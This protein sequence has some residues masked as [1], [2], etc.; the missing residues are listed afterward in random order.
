[1]QWAEG[2][3]TGFPRGALEFYVEPI[4]ANSSS[5]AVDDAFRTQRC[6]ILGS[7]CLK[8]RKSEPQ[9]TIG[10]CVVG[11]QGLPLV[12]CP[13][14]LRRST[15]VFEEAMHL[16]S[17][18]QDGLELVAIPEIGSGARGSIDY[19]LTAFD[20]DRYVDHVGIEFQTLD[21]TGSVWPSREDYLHGRAP[22]AKYNINWRMNA[23]TILIQLHH[24]AP[25]FEAHGKKL[26]L[27]V[28]DAFLD[29]LRQDFNFDDYRDANPADVLHIHSYRL[30]Y[31]PSDDDGGEFK[32]ELADKVSTGLAGVEKS[33][34]AVNGGALPTLEEFTGKLVQKRKRGVAI[35]F[36]QLV[37]GRQPI[38]TAEESVGSSAGDEFS[39]E[40]DGD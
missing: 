13:I 31:S 15:Q 39:D 40:L 19:V 32:M 3:A 7:K 27:V 24:K 10:S 16:L 9:Q 5:Q 38:I 6:P 12:I 36:D 17:G 20:G 29:K 25:V 35:A 18:Y 21:T 8:N 4:T 37:E 14:R 11:H 23:K 22:S 28:Q 1:M 2:Q 30:V 26:L 34:N 33:L